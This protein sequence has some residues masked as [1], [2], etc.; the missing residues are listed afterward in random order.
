MILSS[1]NVPGQPAPEQAVV[2]AVESDSLVGVLHH[3]E[4]QVHAGVLI[5]V[6]GPQYRVGSHRQ[7]LLLARRL[8]AAGVP[9]FRF[10]YRGMGDAS[11]AA[12]DFEVVRDDISAAIDTFAK[13]VPTLRRVVIWGLCDAASAAL[14]Y[15]W[16]DTRV[17]GLV[18]LNPWVRTEAG[19]ARAYLRH[20]Y[21]QRLTSRAFWSKLV[22]GGVNPVAS[23]RSLISFSLGLVRRRRA[24]G[25]TASPV[26]AKSQTARIDTSP[27]LPGAP[28]PERM[29]EGWRRFDGRILLILAG[30][31]LTAAEFRDA[32]AGSP[33]WRGL[34]EQP[35]VS[36]RE[37]A[38]ANHTFARQAWRTQVEDWT[39]EWLSQDD[40]AVEQDVSQTVSQ[41]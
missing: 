36:R 39:L 29:A 15:A 9:V 22:R 25:A 4:A 34:L 16:R 27:L 37:L 20:Y 28:L 30:E 24:S 5:V 7:F 21:L 35:G 40:A 12:R 19:R 26:P 17:S 18:L 32:V 2:F 41:T 8:A 3:G 31:D 1:A 38:E 14:D 33:A 11:G 10:D 13:Q 23:L 6:G